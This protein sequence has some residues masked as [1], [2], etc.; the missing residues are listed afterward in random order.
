V[1]RAATRGPVS[2]HQSL[3]DDGGLYSGLYALQ[4]QGETGA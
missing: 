4:F 3:M 1:E 2:A